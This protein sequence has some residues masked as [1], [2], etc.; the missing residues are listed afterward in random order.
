M[1]NQAI[2]VF[3]KTR[4]FCK[5]TNSDSPISHAVKEAV[6]QSTKNGLLLGSL[7]PTAIKILEVYLAGELLNKSQN[8]AITVNRT[9][10]GTQK[11]SCEEVLS[12]FKHTMFS[13]FTV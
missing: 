4:C 12:G 5:L 6:N 9:F 2:K 11:C 3:K 10:L 7:P 13:K 1:E 8:N